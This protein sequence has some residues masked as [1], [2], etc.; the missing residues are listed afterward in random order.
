M[1]TPTERFTKSDAISIIVGHHEGPAIRN[2]R[3]FFSNINSLR[4]VWWLDIPES[5]LDLQRGIELGLLLYDQRS[6]MLHHLTVPVSFL[7]KNRSGFVRR[8]RAAGGPAICLELSADAL[9]LFKDVRP[10]AA[11]VEFAEH[12]HCSIRVNAEK[13]ATVAKT[14]GAYQKQR[15]NKRKED[16]IKVKGG[17]CVKCGYKKS[18]SALVFHHRDE[19]TKK[20]NISGQNLNKHSWETLLEEANKCDLLCANCHAET[21]DRE[22]WVH[23]NGRRTVKEPRPI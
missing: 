3:F 6:N 12:K 10:T 5:A 20:F 22:G 4:K 16:I 7:R 1:K 23:E 17:G 15:R 19:K 8:D 18:A 14:P 11:G 13:E 9:Q 2:Q 21:H